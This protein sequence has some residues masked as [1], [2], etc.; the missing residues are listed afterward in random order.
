[1]GKLINSLRNSPIKFK[2]K[3]QRKPK[4]NIALDPQNTSNDQI[5]VRVDT[6]ADVNCMNEKI[7]L[8]LFPKVKLKWCLHVLQNF[9]NSAADVQ[10]LG[11]FQAFL[12]FKR[13][14]YQNTFVVTDAS[15]SPN[16]LSHQA[17]FRM[18]ILKACYH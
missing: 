1:M 18:G 8:A 16:L 4:F 11:K 15:N 14:K 9:G 5:I 7:F 3:F 2:L 13:V 10:V 17:T 6:G 12:F